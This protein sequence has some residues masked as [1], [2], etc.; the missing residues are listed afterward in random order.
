MRR[1]VVAPLVLSALFMS[2]SAHSD[3]I[4]CKMTFNMKGWS[5]FYKT[6][7]GAGHIRCSN[8]QAFSVKLDVKGGGLS[9][10]KSVIEKGNGQFSDV[11]S[12]DELFGS[13]AA[14]EAHAG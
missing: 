12:T 1:L 3:G 6:A 4:K 14:A 9:F 2:V 13:Y 8:G 5:A 10:G 7:S 11:A